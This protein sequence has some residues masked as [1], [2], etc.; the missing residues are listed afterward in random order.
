ME[1]KAERFLDAGVESLLCAFVAPMAKAGRIRARVALSRSGR[2][3]LPK[4]RCADNELAGL[5]RHC[6]YLAFTPF[7]LQSRKTGGSAS[8]RQSPMR[9]SLPSRRSMKLAD[10]LPL[11]AI[12]VPEACRMIGIGRTKLYELIRAGD[13]ETVKLGRATLITVSSLRRLIG[14]KPRAL[15]IVRCRSSPSDTQWG[16]R[17]GSDQPLRPEN[18]A[19]SIC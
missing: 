15:I 1:A 7:H 11:L 8:E 14:K 17:W 12:R 16:S 18:N 6:L 5:A 10:P 4:K 13:L 9:G 3:C 2:E 19:R